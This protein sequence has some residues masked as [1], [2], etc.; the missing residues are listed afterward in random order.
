MNRAECAP[1]F[2]QSF[3]SSSVVGPN[4]E[5][6][7]NSIYTD[8]DG[9]RIING[10]N[11]KTKPSSSQSNSVQL[12]TRPDWIEESGSSRQRVDT[13]AYVHDNRGDYKGN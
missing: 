11:L 8:S 5:I 7:N 6:I 1:Q 3:S 9:N 10:E 4:G 2:G 12:L 13:G